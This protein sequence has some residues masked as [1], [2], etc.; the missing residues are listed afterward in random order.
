MKDKRLARFSLI[1][2]RQEK[3]FIPLPP[4]L[5]PPPPPTPE[6]HGEQQMENRR[7]D[8]IFRSD[9]R[10]EAWL[11]LPGPQS[12]HKRPPQSVM[13]GGRG[14]ETTAFTS[15]FILKVWGLKQLCQEKGRDIA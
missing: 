3:A 12:G 13:P 15:S 8:V 10:L 14:L 1:I 4:T 11:L 5:A 2:F 6:S 9:P 7:V